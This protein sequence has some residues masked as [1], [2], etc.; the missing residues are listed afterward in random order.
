MKT[1]YWIAI[2]GAL[3]LLCLGLTLYF[4]QPAPDA[5]AVQ[6]ISRGKVL[7]TLPLSKDAQ[8]TVTTEA[9]T[10]VIT[11]RDGKVAVTEASCPDQYCVHRGFC[12]GG[13]Q[14]V[15]LPNRLVLKFQ[16]K[17]PLDGTTG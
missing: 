6:V 12:S 14:I 9:G 17:A 13:T 3:F 8:V 1:K 2:L 7:H 15:C 11:V 10:N 16:G 4:M 5:A